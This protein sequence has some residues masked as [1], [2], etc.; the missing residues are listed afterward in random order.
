[1]DTEDE[2]DG[3]GEPDSSYVL[4]ANESFLSDQQDREEVPP[5]KEGKYIVFEGQLLELFRVCHTCLA[6]CR[7]TTVVKGSLLTVTSTCE[8]K[9]TRKWRSQPMLGG[10]GAG[11]V[12]FCA[13][14][15]FSGAQVATTF[16]VL[17]SLNIAMITERMYYYYQSG[18]LLPVVKQVYE[19]R[20]SELLEE[21]RGK[22]LDLAGDGRCDSPGFCT[23]YCTYTF[24]EAST[25]RLIHI[26]QVQVRE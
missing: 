10:K 19:R 11:N 14:I 23:K 9:H 5:Q 26:E 25:K 4:S 16:R 12:L 15:R 20:N 17:E 22:N 18:Y 13:G 24:H 7:N 6:L 21:L 1:D 8:N 3:P 2:Y